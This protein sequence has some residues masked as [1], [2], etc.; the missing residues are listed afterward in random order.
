LLKSTAEEQATMPSP[1]RD[2]LE[3]H[4]AIVEGPLSPESR[5]PEAGSLEA[6]GPGV[7]LD[8]LEPGVRIVVATKHSCYRFIVVDGPAQR[9]T[10]TGGSMF[11]ESTEVRI[12]GATTGN[13]VVK[14]GWIGAGL[15]LELSVG[16]KR[17]TTSCVQSV[18]V[19][20]ASSAIA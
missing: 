3:S 1:D 19:E 20:K 17:I 4:S 2:L 6:L 10:V 13:S 9:A 7:K 14:Q 18:A 12:E 16:L 8:T 5:T 11:P 15:R